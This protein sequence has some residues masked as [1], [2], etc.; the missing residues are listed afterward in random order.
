[1]ERENGDVNFTIRNYVEE[2][3]KQGVNLDVKMSNLNVNDLGESFLRKEEYKI[4]KNNCPHLY[5]FIIAQA[6]EW[7]SHTLQWLP[8]RDEPEGKNYS[9][10]KIILGNYTNGYDQSY[11]IIAEAKI[12]NEN[13]DQDYSS[14][15]GCP[16]NNDVNGDNNFKIIKKI[17]HDGDVNIARYMPKK[18]S[19]IATKTNGGVVCIFDIEKQLPMDSDDLAR[20]ELR[21]IGHKADGYGLSWSN[22]KSGHLLSGDYDGNIC[23]WDINDTPNNLTLNPLQKFKI[24]EGE[25]ND[26]A[27]NSKDENLF[28]SV[29]GK[30]LHLW[31][32]RA[33]IIDNPVQYCV[34]H[35]EKINCLSFNPFNEWKIITGSSDK[36]IKLW[37]T[38]KICKSNDM[39]ECVHTFKQLD[40]GV[41]QVGWNPNNETMFASGCYGRRVIVWDI[42]KIGA[43]QNEMD[44]EDGPP[45]MLFVHGGHLG[46]INDLS[47]NPCE[48]MM[49]ASVD[50]ENSVHLWKM[51]EGNYKYYDDD[52]DDNDGADDY[53]P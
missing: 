29:G 20:P 19:I 33:P 51:Y 1:M 25:T 15:F 7:P 35:S 16:N 53:F 47:W 12:P 46:E 10:Q 17:N 8:V 36:T 41:S 49:I 34:A 26:V 24:N 23:I 37:D 40:A 5:D 21:L 30:Y 48:D 39:Y 50:A 13:V 43:M 42:G 45:E 31:D 14:D 27:W 11:L 18:D 9:V 52:D 3:A 32:V 4:W 22:F 44:A 6:L 38:R 2:Y 28:G